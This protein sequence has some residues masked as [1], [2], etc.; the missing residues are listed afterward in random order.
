[1]TAAGPNGYPILAIF[2]R[3]HCKDAKSGND[4]NEAVIMT[5]SGVPIHTHRKLTPFSMGKDFPVGERIETGQVLEVL[6]S[7]VGNLAVLIC[8]DLFHQTIQPL[9]IQ[10]KAN[11]L[12]VPSLSPETGPHRKASS[13]LQAA[14]HASTFVANRWFMDLENPADGTSFFRIPR[15]TDA[16]KPHWKPSA[17]KPAESY[18]IFRLMNEG[19]AK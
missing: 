8:L 6:P 9:V 16:E 17:G 13:T 12:V 5:A 15:S 11:L 4:L 18:L 7:D 19:L 3:C 14:N 2:G 1:M 10:S